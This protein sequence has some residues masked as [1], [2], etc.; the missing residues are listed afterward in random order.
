MSTNEISYDLVMEDEMPFVEGTYRLAGGE[1]QVFIFVRREVDEPEITEATW[2]SGVTGLHLAYPR[3]R[4][5]NQ[6]VVESLLSSHL[7]VEHWKVVR[8]P[9]SIMIR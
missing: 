5:L 9:D 6:S 1:W 7:S 3:E 4:L 2:R 8:G